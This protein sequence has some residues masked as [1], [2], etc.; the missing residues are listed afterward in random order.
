MNKQLL[1]QIK[2]DKYYKYLKE[3]SYF[4]KYLIRNPNNYKNFKKY[5]KEKYQLRITD[6]ISTAIDD[7]ELISNII[8]TIN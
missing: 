2:K 6:K 8:S 4:I 3:N 1:E 7:I 5:I